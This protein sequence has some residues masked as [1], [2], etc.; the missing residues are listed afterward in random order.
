MKKA[1]V[2]LLVLAMLVPMVLVMPAS[3]EAATPDK[4]F[5]TLGWSEF[6][7]KSY[8]YLD[9]L[10]QI[11]WSALG[12]SVK[13]NN[14]TYGSAD[15]DAQVL[16]LAQTLKTAMDKRPAGARYIHTFGPASAYRVAPEN[17]IFMDYAVDQMV[18]IM[19]ALMKKY[20]EIGGQIDGIV[21]DVEFTGT[22]CYYLFDSPSNE[23]QNNTLV[24]NP[25]LLRDIVKD[26]RYKTEIRPLLEEWG[27]IFYDAGDPAKQ[28]AY[29][30]L[31]SLTK[32][33]GSKYAI[34]RDIWNVV[35]RN[36]LNQYNNEWLY[37]PTQK[38]YPDIHCSDYQS[39]DAASWLKLATVT[40]DGTVMSGGNG[41]KIHGICNVAVCQGILVVDLIKCVGIKNY[42]FLSGA[43]DVCK[44]FAYV[45]FLYRPF[46][47]Y[48]KNY[49]KS[50]L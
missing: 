30:E 39:N 4:P 15:F 38:Y 46:G 37:E 31:Y 21:V 13:L 14:V 23:Y 24:S 17:G 7:E 20:K 42:L 35:M 32:N 3:A 10:Y 48:C 40:D 44:Y 47:I 33:A 25:D 36:H 18:V 6:D 8:P 27:F 26:K 1:L 9:G 28:E 11:N 19:D 12:G 2:M 45:H 29:T 43:L 5:Y 34:S 41:K 50:F 49:T 16:K 22:S